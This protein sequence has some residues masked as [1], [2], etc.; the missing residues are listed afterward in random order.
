MCPN[1]EFRCPFCV[2]SEWFLSVLICLIWAE[3]WTDHLFVFFDFFLSGARW[4]FHWWLC[5]FQYQPCPCQLVSSFDVLLIPFGIGTIRRVS[6]NRQN[7]GTTQ[8]RLLHR[9]ILAA[10]LLMAEILHQLIGS[11]SLYRVLYIPGTLTWRTCPLCA[12]FLQVVQFVQRSHE[13]CIYRKLVEM[14]FFPPDTPGRWRFTLQLTLTPMR[15]KID[16]QNIH[17]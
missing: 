3:V 14:C 16:T 1:G 5:A 13:W 11:L 12:R 17:N 9:S 10:I 2:F 6:P 7:L 15:S 4:V 8:W